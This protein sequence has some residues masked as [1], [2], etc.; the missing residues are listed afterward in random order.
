[1]NVLILGWRVYSKEGKSHQHCGECVC[2]YT[3]CFYTVRVHTCIIYVFLN[4]N[5]YVFG[6]RRCM[7][8]K[9]VI[10][11]RWMQANYWMRSLGFTPPCWSLA[12]I[13]LSH[14]VFIFCSFFICTLIY[15]FVSFIFNSLFDYIRIQ[16][17]S[18]SFFK[19]IISKKLIKVNVCILCSSHIHIWLKSNQI[20]N[21]SFKTRCVLGQHQHTLHVVNVESLFVNSF[22]RF[23]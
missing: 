13:F 17:E 1:M 23:L 2:E 18:I 22:C 8:L 20:A 16:L 9:G 11:G 5:V 3:L 7:L 14:A 19:S 12:G 6:C 15:P 21:L 10:N 4:R